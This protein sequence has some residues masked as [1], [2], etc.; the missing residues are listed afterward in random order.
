MNKELYLA[1]DDADFQADFSFVDFPASYLDSM[2]QPAAQAL[3]SMKELEQG[4]I[5]NPD[6][7]RMVGHYWLRAPEMAPDDEIAGMIRDTVAR[8]KDLADQVHKGTLQ[9][10][11]GPFTDL[12]V[13][14][15]GG[16]A[17]GPQFVGKALG[18]P[19]RDKMRVHFF[20][21]T[22]DSKFGPTKLAT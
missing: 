7:E 13:I 9:A 16:S 12:L 22:A 17:L 11:A 5:A 8:V 14:G 18:H 15:I 4:S 6:E 10:P 21:N 2:A 20:D 19:D 3:A 1:F